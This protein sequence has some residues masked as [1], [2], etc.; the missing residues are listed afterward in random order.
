[1]K[2]NELKTALKFAAP[3]LSSNDFIPALSQ[4]CFCG[5]MVYAWNDVT[6]IIVNLNSGLNC[7][8]QGDTLLGI[9]DASPDMNEEVDISVKEDI[10]LLKMAKGNV[11]LPVKLPDEFVFEVPDT[12][13]QVKIP[14]DASFIEALQLC[15]LCVSDNALRL[16]LNGVTIVVAQGK[17]FLYASNGTI[18]G[19]YEGITAKGSLTAIIP[20]FA[21]EQIISLHKVL[22]D[23]KQKAFVEIGKTF[24]QVTFPNVMLISKLIAE[25]AVDFREVFDSVLDDLALYEIPTAL[26][27]EL[28]KAHILQGKELEKKCTLSQDKSLRVDAVG[29]LGEV[30]SEMKLLRKQ[31]ERQTGFQPEQML[32]VLPYVL[33]MGITE[34][35]RIV[36][37][38]KEAKFTYIIAG[39]SI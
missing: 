2:L 13:P 34:N 28:T 17:A 33:K 6:A 25:K 8:L 32:R 12:E 19:K 21:C 37:Q 14:L 36:M 23:E 18:A 30:H 20:K 7:G 35:H 10:A 39:Y 9:L 4:F 29:T 1:M 26:T 16:N 5:D 3:A 11:K 27:P 22:V 15:L 31:P 24:L 38:D